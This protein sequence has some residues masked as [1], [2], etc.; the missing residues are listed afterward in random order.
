MLRVNS[1]VPLSPEERELITTTFETHGPIVIGEKSAHGSGP[2][3]AS[4]PAGGVVLTAIGWVILS[5]V[6]VVGA[7]SLIVLKSI[8]STF[9]S[10]AGKYLLQRLKEKR[11][12]KP[13]GKQQPGVPL[14]TV[15]CE[16]NAET[17]VLV[18]IDTDNLG[19]VEQLLSRL[20]PWSE[21][22]HSQTPLAVA[23]FDAES[24]EWSVASRGGLA[25]LHYFNDDGE[26]KVVYTVRLGQ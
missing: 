10:E 26:R 23:R 3:M 19:A 4:A 12:A 17:V 7:G 13:V 11:N 22:A 21:G 24:A 9:G 15:L 8:L 16:L 2:C 14:V 6:G 5:V 20:Q 18:T 25:A 1:Q